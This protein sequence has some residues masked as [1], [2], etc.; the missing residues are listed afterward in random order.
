M[1]G[2]V[3][4]WWKRKS[5]LNEGLRVLTQSGRPALDTQENK[6]MAT[7]GIP[8]KISKDE[9]A[10]VVRTQ[11]SRG[12]PSWRSRLKSGGDLGMAKPRAFRRLLID[13]QLKSRRL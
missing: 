5:E 4:T 12:L 9:K 3:S 1:E 10:R 11:I 7:A 13:D 8:D 2:H 6:T